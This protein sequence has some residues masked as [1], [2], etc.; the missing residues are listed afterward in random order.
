MVNSAPIIKGSIL[1]DKGCREDQDRFT[2]V[3]PS[4]DWQAGLRHAE[5]IGLGT[6]KY[7]LVNVE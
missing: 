1:E 7:I 6:Q 2:T 3:H 5:T 4:T